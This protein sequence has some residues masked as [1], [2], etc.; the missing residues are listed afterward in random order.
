MDLIDAHHLPSGYGLA[1]LNAMVRW[2]RVSPV[3]ARKSSTSP[4]IIE[5]NG[6][7]KALASRSCH[8]SVHGFCRLRDDGHPIQTVT[9]T[10]ASPSYR[11][12]PTWLVSP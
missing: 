3:T 10:L 4:V 9:A 5:A 12:V 2:T 7:D 11:L 1:I 6:S 8:R